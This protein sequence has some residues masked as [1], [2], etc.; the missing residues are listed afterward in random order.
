MCVCVCLCIYITRMNFFLV[1]KYFLFCYMMTMMMMDTK[2]ASQCYTI[3]CNTYIFVV[4]FIH[5]CPFFFWIVLF[6]RATAAALLYLPRLHNPNTHTHTHSL[7][8]NNLSDIRV[9]FHSMVINIDIILFDHID[10]N[11]SH[12]HTHL[13]TLDPYET[14]CVIV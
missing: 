5:Y 12:T 9:K 13:H 7:S 1:H 6:F 2:L 8:L 11:H 3:R 10:L 4:F 14:N